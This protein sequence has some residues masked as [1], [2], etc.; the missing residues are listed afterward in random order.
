MTY[1]FNHILRVYGNFEYHEYMDAVDA[2]LVYKD[3]M[4]SGWFMTNDFTYCRRIHDPLNPVSKA[5]SRSTP[6]LPRAHSYT[7]FAQ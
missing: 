4:A 7:G 2:D 6:T 1:K 3:Y 5:P